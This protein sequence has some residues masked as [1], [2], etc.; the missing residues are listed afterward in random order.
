MELMLIYAAVF[1]G[2][3]ILFERL[4][5]TFASRFGKSRS[6]NRRL[7]LLENKESTL[8]VYKGM[9]RERALDYDRGGFNLTVQLRRLFAQSGMKLNVSKAAI[10][11]LA[12]TV[13]LWLLL[14]YFGF[15]SFPKLIIVFLVLL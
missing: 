4:T 9:V 13:V 7:Q 14:S 8:D 1:I 15:S 11:A 10:Y 12:V 5:R 3:L 6:L 2:G